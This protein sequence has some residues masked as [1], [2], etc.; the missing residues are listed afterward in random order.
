MSNKSNHTQ[1]LI[2]RHGQT[3]WNLAKKLQGHT[4][5]PLNKTGMAQAHKAA[6]FL[7]K[8]ELNPS[9][10]YSSDLQRAHKTAQIIGQS[11]NIPVVPSALLREA[12][13]GEA[14][15]WTFD[16]IN[17][18]LEQH[19]IKY[20]NREEQQKHSPIPGAESPYEVIQRINHYI[21]LCAA[22]HPGEVTILVSHGGVI[23]ALISQSSGQESMPLD[24][25]CIAHFTYQSNTKTLDFHT[26]HMA[27]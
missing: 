22:S 27:K 21:E 24:N 1:F 14:E 12:H 11:H 7:H 17:P 25:C 23:K 2:I 5:I 4:D 19:A 6:R 9:R 26:I 3:D 16:K 20:P 18:I 13:Y 10:I 15:G 8:F